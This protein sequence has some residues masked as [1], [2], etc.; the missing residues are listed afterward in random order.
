[1]VAVAALPAMGAGNENCSIPRE[2]RQDVA[3]SIGLTQLGLTVGL[4]QL[5][6]RVHR[7]SGQSA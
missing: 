3:S 1:M 6:V 7:H 2:P 5:S 4:S